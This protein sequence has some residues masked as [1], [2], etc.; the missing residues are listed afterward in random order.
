MVCR[1]GVLCFV[2][3]V[4]CNDAMGSEGASCCGV[5]RREDGMHNWTRR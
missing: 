3:R 4:K 5:T 1:P 2:K